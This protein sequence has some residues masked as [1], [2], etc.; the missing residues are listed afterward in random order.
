MLRFSCLVGATCV[1]ALVG[2]GSDSSSP[3]G[4]QEGL[5][6]VDSDSNGSGNGMW[7]GEPVAEGCGPDGGTPDA[8]ADGGVLQGV[9]MVKDTTRF[10][11]S[12]G[13]AER[14][15]DLSANP[16]E[17]LVFNGATFTRFLGSAAEGGWRF[18]NVPSGPFYLRT[19]STYFVTSSRHVEI[20][21]NRLGR[22]EA[23]YVDTFSVPLQLNL[24]NMAPWQPWTSSSAPGTDLQ[25]TSGQVDLY[26]TPYLFETPPDGAT[27]VVTADA[28]L[29]SNLG[30]LPVFEADRVDRLYINQL[31]GFSAGTLPNGQ[32]LGYAAVERSV[33]AG[34]F[35]YRP[36]S[37]SA[38]PVTGW[39]QP[40]SM[41][42]FPLEWRLPQFAGFASVV[43]PNA[44]PGVPR[45]DVVPGAHGLEGGW[46]GYTGELLTLSLPR[47]SAYDF[48]TRM[49]FGNPYPSNWGLV[50]VV[51]YT[52][53]NQEA[54]PDGSGRV[55]NLTA[56]YTSWDEFDHLIAG[57]VTPKVSPPR[58]FT[59]DGVPAS[60]Q[61]NVGTASPVFAWAPPTLGTP[62]AYRVSIL[63]LDLDLGFSSTWRTLYVPGSATQVR[64]PP[65]LLEPGTTYHAT[66]TAIDS[67]L[68]DIQA[69][70]FRTL[71][72]LP[73]RAAG[74]VSSYFTTP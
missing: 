48:T 69:S 28:E 54:L 1:A 67:P 9:V 35:D 16:P 29:S 58:S 12:V 50:G 3:G 42:E 51:S 2:C 40:V 5:S 41:R 60:V 68:L 32:P 30:H 49:K 55:G 34:A 63:R 47:G 38:I 46:I 21:R 59:I 71:E 57:P 25:L 39:L 17:V 11:T 26:A 4:L 73:Y 13:V 27:S 62:T 44:L 53:R 64:L 45:L 19:G 20:G 56:G 36:D 70:P 31:S 74:T 23:E 6:S 14:Q 66:V 65:D 52:F 24:L 43:H 10:Y 37:A 15:E 18:T 33:H 61:R 8:G 72:Q 7:M 22:P